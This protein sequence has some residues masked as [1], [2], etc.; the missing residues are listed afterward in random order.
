MLKQNNPLW[1]V[2]LL[3]VGDLAFSFDLLP[4]ALFIEKCLNSV[5]EIALILLTRS[6]F[7]SL[8]WP[9][10]PPNSSITPRDLPRMMNFSFSCLSPH[11]LYGND[12]ILIHVVW[13]LVNLI[14]LCA[15]FSLHFHIP[16]ASIPF[17]FH[18][19]FIFFHDCHFVFSYFESIFPGVPPFPVSF[20][21][22]ILPVSFLLFR[23]IPYGW[24]ISESSFMNYLCQVI[25]ARLILPC[26]GTP[27]IGITVIAWKAIWAARVWT[28]GTHYGA[29]R[30][31]DLNLMSRI[32][33]CSK[34]RLCWVVLNTFAIYPSLSPYSITGGKSKILA[35]KLAYRTPNLWHFL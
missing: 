17:S 20:S 18:R 6:T 14:R 15:A 12:F 2:A 1:S 34:V 21:R 28:V 7:S 27:P 3:V 8:P 16:I 10:S 22:V 13:I 5:E 31:F 11:H 4:E 26:A 32:S 25:L 19:P 29:F 24:H 33:D 35:P 30:Y 23:S 9:L